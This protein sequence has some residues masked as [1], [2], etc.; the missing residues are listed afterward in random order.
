LFSLIGVAAVYKLVESATTSKTWAAIAGLVMAAHFAMPFLAVRNL[1]EMFGGTLWAA[2][3][4]YLYKHRSD[5]KL[6]F[7]MISGI[8]A[9]LAWMFRFQMIFAF[10][11]VPLIL[12]YEYR[13][14]LPALY[15]GCGVIAMILLAGLADW[16][17]VGSFLGTSINY[18]RQGLSEGALY[19]TSHFIYLAVIV[20]SFIPPVSLIV[21]YLALRRRFWTS[22][23]ALTASTAAFVIIHS[24]AANR[25]E[26]FVI[27][28]L[29]ALIVVFVLACHQH[30]QHSG[31]FR[32]HRKLSLAVLAFALIVNIAALGPLT[33][34]YG[35]KGLV[36]P[37]VKIE[38]LSSSKPAVLFMSPE[39]SRIFPVSYG[40]FDLIERT[41]VYGWGDL[42]L[43]RESW[44]GERGFDYYLL[45][46]LRSDDLGRYKDSLVSRVGPVDLV[47]HVGPSTIDNILYY[48][49]PRHNV[50]N[51]AWAFRKADP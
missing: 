38:R 25:Q 37:L 23:L 7:L 31:F 11:V 18:V 44:S 4:L 13:R 12:W 30:H 2:S 15:Y 5:N 46:P 9:G 51:E 34:N 36:G 3:L 6:A 21:M 32:R 16:M 24:L 10:W 29:P 42:D 26:R 40:G 17:W 47:F 14:L 48:L 41:Y 1:I 43:V 50:T 49:N 20:A 22:H 27:P 19:S 28:M 45:Y 39:K 35:H 8:L 33:V